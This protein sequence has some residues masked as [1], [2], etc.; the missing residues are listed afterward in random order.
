MSPLTIDDADTG[1]EKARD[2]RPDTHGDRG[3]GRELSVKRC[4]D[5]ERGPG[6]LRQLRR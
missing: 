2:Q 6:Q 4:C 3:E 1:E 5:S